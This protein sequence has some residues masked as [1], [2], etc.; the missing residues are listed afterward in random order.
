MEPYAT[1]PI[2]T[3][4]EAANYLRVHRKTLYR[5]TKR[6]E[7][8]VIKS[9]SG[10]VRFRLSDLEAYLDSQRVPARHDREE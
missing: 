3:G 7:L 6:G 9:P 5:L 4:D 8:A 10:R 1:D 2:L